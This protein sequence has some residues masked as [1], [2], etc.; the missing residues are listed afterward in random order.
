MGTEFRIVVIFRRM[1]KMTRKEHEG[2]F[3]GSGYILHLHL[4]DSYR[5]IFTWK[6]IIK[7]YTD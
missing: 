3:R 6:K 2:E 7:I 4:N 1:G 5:D